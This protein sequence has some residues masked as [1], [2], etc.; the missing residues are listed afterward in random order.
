MTTDIYPKSNASEK[1]V[2]DQHTYST[3]VI[4]IRE[5]SYSGKEKHAIQNK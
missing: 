1:E 5:K 2:N 3:H 4:P